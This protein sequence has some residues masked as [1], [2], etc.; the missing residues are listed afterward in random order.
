MSST[1]VELVRSHEGKINLCVDGKF[2]A[3]AVF[4]GIQTLANGRM[5]AVFAIELEN[6]TMREHDNVVVLSDRRNG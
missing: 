1:N 2:A 5:G 6:L 4:S 3:G